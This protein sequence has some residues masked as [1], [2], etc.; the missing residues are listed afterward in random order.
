MVLIFNSYLYVIIRILGRQY[1][2]SSTWG[3]RKWP[4]GSK[5]PNHLKSSGPSL[6]FKEIYTKTPQ[7]PSATG[8]TWRPKV[9]IL[10]NKILP[11][12]PLWMESAFSEVTTWTSL[13]IVNFPFPSLPSRL[14]FKS[15]FAINHWQKKPEIP[16]SLHFISKYLNS[17]SVV[18]PD[19]RNFYFGNVAPTP[20]LLRWLFLYIWG[21]WG[22]RPKRNF[23]K[24]N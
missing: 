17:S 10:S 9:C 12:G 24:S 8:K 18:Q 20:L 2:Y 5:Q 15:F 11:F 1:W 7:L 3:H 13:K 6:H 19:V 21:F 22:L 4:Q 23:K 14:I 16:R